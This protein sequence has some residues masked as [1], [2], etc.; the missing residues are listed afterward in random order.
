VRP[1]R[2][3]ARRHARSSGRLAAGEHVGAPSTSDWPW[4]R[5]RK[6]SR[7]SPASRNS[8]TV[9]EGA[10]GPSMRIDST[11]WRQASRRGALCSVMPDFVR[12]H[13]LA[14]AHEY[15]GRATRP[16]TRT[17][18]ACTSDRR[19]TLPARSRAC[20]AGRSRA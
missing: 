15:P 18:G 4:R 5:S 12:S 3:Q 10:A 17:A 13:R 2:V 7:S 20:A 8:T 14:Q 11:P 1:D 19:R 16:P 9:A 6:T